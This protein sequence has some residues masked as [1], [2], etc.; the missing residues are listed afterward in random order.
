MIFNLKKYLTKKQSFEEI[1]PKIKLA[2]VNKEYIVD[3]KISNRQ[4]CDNLYIIPVV[5]TKSHVVSY[6]RHADDKRDIDDIY[7]DA[8]VNTFEEEIEY[9]GIGKRIDD[10]NYDFYE[11]VGS[12]Y[13]LSSLII[14]PYFLKKYEGEYGVIF[15]MISRNKYHLA[16]IPSLKNINVII[17]MLGMYCYNEHT[18][19]KGKKIVPDLYY[20]K[21]GKYKTIALYDEDE[22]FTLIIP[23]DLKV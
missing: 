5:D 23:E 8:L 3:S 16:P 14:N 18:E 6:V 9:E 21:D 13:F 10:I 12:S 22:N 7:N 1:I 19:V 15:S 11:I 17:S 4:I 20:Y 2:V